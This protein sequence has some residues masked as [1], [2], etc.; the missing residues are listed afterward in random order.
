MNAGFIRRHFRAGKSRM[1]PTRRFPKAAWFGARKSEQFWRFY[2]KAEIAGDRLEVQFNRSAIEKYGLDDLEAWDHLPEVVM[3]HGKFYDVDW[4]RLTIFVKRHFRRY[5]DAV[6]GK[7]RG[8][9]GNLDRLVRY[10]RQVGVHNPTR[11]L[12]PM[13]INE[14]VRRALY[15]W[16]E[17]WRKNG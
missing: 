5:P 13:A 9:R 15:V 16:R 7:A 14:E 8:M 6:L 12:V 4:T 2:P 17:E 10:L 11:F 3:K 1:R